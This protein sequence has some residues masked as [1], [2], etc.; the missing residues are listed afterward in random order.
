M[1][2]YPLYNW[3]LEPTISFAYYG[4]VSGGVS[5]N[6]ALAVD[7]QEN[8]FFAAVVQGQNP[9]ASPT[10]SSSY[11]TYNNIVVGSADVNGNLLWYKFFPELVVSANQSQVSLV[12]GKNNDLYVAFVTP[13]A[14]AKCFNMATIPRWCPPLYTD[15]DVEGSDD[16]V[17][18]R[19]DYTSTK[20][21]VTWVQQNARLNS[22][23]N[24]TVPQ[25]A[26]DTNNGLL[27][28]A[29]QTNGDILCYYPVGNPTVALSCFTLAGAQLWFECQGN[30]NSAGSN[31]NPVVAADLSGGVYVAFETTETVQGGATVN[32]QQIEMV[33]FQTAL[34]IDGK[35]ASYNR[36][37]VLSQNGTIQTAEPGIS[38]APSVTC[39]GINV[40]VAFL[41]TG[42]VAGNYPTGSAHDLVVA[43]VT[44]TGYTPWIQQGIQFNRPPY[45]YVDAGF[46]YITADR[47]L[48]SYD[49]PNVVISLQ[50]HIYS[51]KRARTYLL[52][53]GIM[54]C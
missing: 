6:P 3:N 27:Y 41:T 25:L 22:V 35:L 9:T 52:G 47:S 18:A 42:S 40:F 44:S 36:S 30:I 12:A 45:T 26:I 43:K 16:I 49:I 4:G 10:I 14:V 1:S 28:I 8:T 34:T 48:S 19:I 13:A 53:V 24:E 38:S 31:T 23:Y 46:P 2:T 54:P 5:G 20:Q 21:S 29:Y 32:G 15:L 7:S 17:L 51:T 11:W 39:D 37:W 33:K 50:T